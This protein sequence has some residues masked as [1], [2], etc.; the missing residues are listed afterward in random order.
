MTE[1]KYFD[2]INL[3]NYR[4]FDVKSK[5]ATVK[6]PN[7]Y[8]LEFD[9]LEF[10]PTLYTNFKY[11]MEYK[12]GLE[13]SKIFRIRNSI[14]EGLSSNIFNR[15]S[16]DKNLYLCSEIDY[17]NLMRSK[18]TNLKF[19]CSLYFQHF[20]LFVRSEISKKIS[21]WQDI[22]KYS[23]KSTVEEKNENIIIGIP[24]EKQIPIRMHYKF[25]NP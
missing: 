14:S 1:K 24:H 15:E 4:N 12:F 23:N 2:K 10:I 5:Y 21:S 8:S 3:E 11:S 16:N 9:T 7:L 13:L 19:I 17:Y 18:N 22:M 20:L 6:S 25:L